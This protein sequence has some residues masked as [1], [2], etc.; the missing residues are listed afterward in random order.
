MAKDLSKLTNVVKDISAKSFEKANEKKVVWI[1][2]ENLLDHPLN[3]EDLTYTTDIEEHIKTEGFRYPLTVTRF[4]IDEKD[5]YYIVS[6]HRSRKAGRKLGKD[7]FPC[8]IEDYATEDDVYHAIL[9]A[10]TRRNYDPLDLVSRYI[11]WNKY[12]DRIGYKGSRADEIGK[13]L[14]IS[15]KQAEKYKAFTKIIPEFWQLVRENDAAKDGLYQLAPM[16]EEKQHEIFNLMEECNP[17]N[18]KITVYFERDVI[19]AYRSGIRNYKDY[20]E[21]I[22]DK[23]ELKQNK[24]PAHVNKETSVLTERGGTVVKTID[25]QASPVYEKIEKDVANKSTEDFPIMSKEDMEVAQSIGVDDSL[26]KDNNK[27]EIVIKKDT[28]KNKRSEETNENYQVKSNASEILRDMS[29]LMSKINLDGNY[30]SKEDI[31]FICKISNKLID[32]IVL[33]LEYLSFKK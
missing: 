2:D 1:K 15:P 31:D 30:K 27:D 28:I 19:A 16:S 29:V 4:G 26:N 12:L 21:Y 7:E 33:E 8:I 9:T 23:N 25:N 32:N 6:G 13:R 11:K 22:N 24:E 17:S 18:E 20:L 5:K 10:N 3:D 14:G